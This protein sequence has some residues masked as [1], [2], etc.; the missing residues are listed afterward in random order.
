MGITWEGKVVESSQHPS[1][2][3]W[4]APTPPDLMVTLAMYLFSSWQ[5][6]QTTYGLHRDF[7][8]LNLKLA[9]L[10]VRQE[11]V[12]SAITSRALHDAGMQSRPAAFG[13]SL[14]FAAC[15][16][17]ADRQLDVARNNALLFL[18]LANQR[19]EGFS[20]TDSKHCTPWTVSLPSRCCQPA[21][22]SLQRHTP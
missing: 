14:A 20:V 17:V 9:F 22:G 13:L 2:V 10:R 16:I 18:L 5:L 12:G 19:P 3:Q 15:L 4:K 1:Y 7:L 8:A 6:D 11:F 21:P